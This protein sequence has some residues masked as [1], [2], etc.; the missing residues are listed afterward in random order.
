MIPN[1]YFD[2]TPSVSLELGRIVR[3]PF[4][5]NYSHFGSGYDYHPELTRSGARVLLARTALPVALVDAVY[6][7]T[8]AIT[9]SYQLVVDKAPQHQRRG[10]WQMF[11]AGLTGSPM[12]GNIQF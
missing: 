12:G 6:L 4:E 7:G 2:D 1:G 5:R 9:E 3:N 11:A 10:L 8:Y